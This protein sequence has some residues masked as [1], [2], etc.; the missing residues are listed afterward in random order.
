M[1]KDPTDLEM[2][3]LIGDL[4][5]LLAARQDILALPQGPNR[6][7]LISDF[8]QRSTLFAAL[9]CGSEMLSEAY[10]D[11]CS[12]SRQET[13]RLLANRIKMVSG[14]FFEQEV[15]QSLIPH[16]G[17]LLSAAFEATAISQGDDPR[18][19]ARLPARLRPARVLWGKYAALRWDA[20]LEAGGIALSE[21]RNAIV[22]AFGLAEWGSTKHWKR[23]IE[24]VFGVS[25][26]ER[27]LAA[28]RIA[29]AENRRPAWT[30]SPK[31]PSLKGSLSEDGRQYQLTATEHKAAQ[32]RG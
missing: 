6:T 24:A 14:L 20:Y 19:F 15:N 28:A 3:Q 12:D 5:G 9:V 25:V 21:R 13:L 8:V 18:L 10:G 7:A 4:K 23:E 29:G 30:S 2:E 31:H 26:L 32:S 1:S 27:K 22:Q 17:S 16:P 11:P